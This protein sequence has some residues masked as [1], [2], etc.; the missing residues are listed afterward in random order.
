MK[1]TL[2]ALLACLLLALPARAAT[3]SAVPLADTGVVLGTTQTGDGDSTNTMDR[4]YTLTGPCL[5]QIT[6]TIGATPTV[7]VDIKG[8]APAAIRGRTKY[9]FHRTLQSLLRESY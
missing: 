5:L 2:Y 6:S 9:S 7:K 8:S 1:R 4:G 3:V